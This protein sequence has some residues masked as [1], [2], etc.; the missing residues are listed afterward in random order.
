MKKKIICILPSFINN[1]GHEFSFFQILRKISVKL[2]NELIVVAPKEN[3]LK[4]KNKNFLKI[5]NSSNLRKITL[6]TNFFF[7]TFLIIKLLKK[8]KVDKKDSIFIDGY[9]QLFLLLITIIIFFFKKKIFLIIYCRYNLNNFSTFFQNLYFKIIEKY[10]FKIIILTDTK[11]LTQY[12]K[13]KLNLKA[14][15]MP[16][17]HTFKFKK[18]KKNQK[19]N[20]SNIIFFPGKIRKDKFSKNFNDFLKSNK[21]SNL[22]IFINEKYN[23]NLSIKAKIIKLKNNLSRDEYQKIFDKTDFIILPYESN[24]YK[25]RSSG[26]FVEAI[27]LNKTV[28]VSEKTWMANELQKYKLNYLIIK[29][30]DTIKIEKFIDIEKNARHQLK[31]KIMS[32]KYLKFH[33]ENNFCSKFIKILNY[34]R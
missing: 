30:W 29:R 28:L 16:I 27:S 6:V 32:K 11:N 18:F 26:I 31:M 23:N 21:N 20:K 19:K 2:K 22:E 12:I 9:N 34:D 13:E 1:D 14:K 24:Y 8:V 15:L 10:S 25:Y 33:N 4:I 17:P 5:L 7:N 3:N